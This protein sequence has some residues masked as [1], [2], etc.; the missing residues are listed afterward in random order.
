MAVRPPS[1]DDSG[2]E[3]VEFGIAALGARVEDAGVEFP[4]GSEELVSALGDPGVPVDAQGNTVR[5][6]TVLAEVGR[7]E[8]ESEREL[9]DAAHPVFEAYR[10]KAGGSITG[11][12]RALLPF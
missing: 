8:F 6:S 12:L 11:R 10:Q 7:S 3:S 4:V 9:L 5:L 1:G 2:P